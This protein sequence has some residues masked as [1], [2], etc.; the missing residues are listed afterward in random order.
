MKNL[1][2]LETKLS[3]ALTKK[4][5]KFTHGQ[6]TYVCN[7]D[8][9]LTNGVTFNNWSMSHRYADLMVEKFIDLSNLNEYQSDFNQL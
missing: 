3:E 2:S 8:H 9:Y 5:M 1:T 7:S 6:L 4:G